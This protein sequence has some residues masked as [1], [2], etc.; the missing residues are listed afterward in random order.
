[1]GDESLRSAVLGAEAQ[2]IIRT[3]ARQLI[4]TPWFA[5]S[6]RED[7]QQELTL[8]VLRHIEKFDSKKGRLAAFIQQIVESH[9]AMLLRDRKR[10]KR[11]PGFYA[12][13]IETLREGVT[14]DPVSGSGAVSE[15]DARRRLGLPDAD[16]QESLELRAA[17]ARVI[18]GLPSDLADVWD[19]LVRGNVASTARELGISRRQVRNALEEIRRRFAAAGLDEF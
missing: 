2:R 1:M 13:S 15:A 4:R 16:S 3:K 5:T 7:V 17:I 6:E 12:R 9:S 8:H 14:D 19:R 11:A 18:A 10:A